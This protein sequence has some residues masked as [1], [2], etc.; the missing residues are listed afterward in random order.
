MDFAPF[1][2]DIGRGA[3]GARALLRDQARVFFAAMLDGSLPDLELGAALIAWRIKGES[4][5][6]L[7]GFKDALDAVT[8]TLA[9]PDAP[10]CVVLPSYNGARRQPNLMPLVALLL[11]RDGVP[12][13]IHGLH[14]FEQ[15]ENSMA[16][17]RAL[18]IP[19]SNS[20]AAT[21]RD[22]VGNRRI[23]AIDINALVPGMARLVALRARLG[24]RSCAHTLV[25]LVNPCHERGVRVVAVTHDEYL[26]KLGVILG[27]DGGR[28]LLMRGTEGEAY[29]NP[30]HPPPMTVYVNGHAQALDRGDERLPAPG[31]LPDTPEVTDNVAL[32]RAILAGDK[33]CPA[34]IE[35]QVAA[36][37]TLACN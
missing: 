6:E 26:E 28:A 27:I 37:K 2:K 9:L 33:P 30:R 12:A 32:I 19:L 10:R 23:S 24:L 21:T 11:A 17:F 8:V 7:L 36:L 29:A 1:I 4:V 13:L 3:K 18:D 25:K 5:E 31:S 34:S 20:I 14:G 22:L 16:L 35:A 15:R